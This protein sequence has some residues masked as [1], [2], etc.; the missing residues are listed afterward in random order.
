MS[1]N[2]EPL[3]IRSK[4]REGFRRAS[5]AYVYKSLYKPTTYLRGHAPKQDEE[6][7][8]KMDDLADRMQVD[9]NELRREIEMALIPAL[10]NIIAPG[11]Q[12]PD[13]EFDKHKGKFDLQSLL[14]NVMPYGTMEDR[15]IMYENTLSHIL[16]RRDNTVYY[17][18]TDM[19][20]YDVIVN[21]DHKYTPTLTE[22][23]R[24]IY[25]KTT[26]NE[27][28]IKKDVLR[29]RCDDSRVA[30]PYRIIRLVGTSSTAMVSGGKRATFTM[31]LNEEQINEGKYTSDVKFADIIESLKLC[32]SIEIFRKDTYV[33]VPFVIENEGLD[34]GVVIIHVFFDDDSNSKALHI[35]MEYCSNLLRNMYRSL[36]KTIRDKNEEAFYAK[37][38]GGQL[39][40]DVFKSLKGTLCALSGT[41]FH[42][43]PIGTQYSEMLEE[44]AKGREAFDQSETAIA[45]AFGAYDNLVDFTHSLLAM[46]AMIIDFNDLVLYH[47]MSNTDNKKEVS[48]MISLIKST[49][50]QT[51]IS[52][53]NLM[54]D[55][56]VSQVRANGSEKKREELHADMIERTVI[57]TS[58]LYQE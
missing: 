4:P 33:I 34:N 50:F 40:V 11:E 20:G 52:E 39:P 6:F 26:L 13:A 35:W 31:N 48:K 44:L 21:L 3:R 49:A 53:Y 43:V 42:L 18:S 41:E 23:S 37:R 24:K 30:A 8:D 28:I 36:L 45:K 25:Y 27:Q 47:K 29:I 46:L 19:A 16:K 22:E 2:Y 57:L 51:V 58:Y 15:A 9:G 54:A 14:C 32:T 56:D 17:M 38:L 7:E 5:A 12:V 1:F 10:R 55:D